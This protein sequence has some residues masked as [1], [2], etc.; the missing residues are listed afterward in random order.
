MT[1]E[2][3]AEL[4]KTGKIEWHP[5]IT[6]QGQVRYA[7]FNQMVP[8]GGGNDPVAEGH[9]VFMADEWTEKGGAVGDEMELAPSD[10]RLVV[11]EVRPAAHYQGRAWQVHVLF[12]RKRVN[13]K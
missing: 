6:L 4:G 1:T 11:L 2:E 5:P 7:K 8:S 13:A 12:Y 9:I 10:S 3:D